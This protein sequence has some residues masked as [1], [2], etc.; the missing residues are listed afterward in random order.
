MGVSEEARPARPH[1][2]AIERGFFVV[3]EEMKERR[4][5]AYF[6]EGRH[7]GRIDDLADLAA[8]VRLDRDEV[9]NP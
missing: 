5:S 3:S 4:Q 7:T 9:T 2:L 8:N 1:G 6:V